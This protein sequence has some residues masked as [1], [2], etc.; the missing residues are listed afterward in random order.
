MR[1]GIDTNVLVYA[2][3]PQFDE[4]PAVRRYLLD[5]LAEPTETL[6]VTP[7]V[8][9]ELVHLLTDGRRFDPPLTMAEALAVARLYLG[10]SNVECLAPDEPSVA[11]AFE[12]LERH[13]LDRKRISDTL[14][15]ATLLRHRVD[16]LVT[17]NPA[18]FTVFEEL[19]L[20]DPR[21]A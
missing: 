12:L 1:R 21:T 15:A 2:H 6:V 5:L 8:L 17:C 4:H 13:R 11:L 14:F 16:H 7:L 3:L 9:H 18:D 10:R 19:R 20:I